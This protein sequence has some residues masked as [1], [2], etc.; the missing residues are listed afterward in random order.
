MQAANEQHHLTTETAK[1]TSLNQVNEQNHQN[2]KQSDQ[3]MQKITTASKIELKR[4]SEVELGCNASNLNLPNLIQ[5]AQEALSHA[6]H[7]HK[8][9]GQFYFLMGIE[10]SITRTEITSAKH[11]YVVVCSICMEITRKHLPGL[12]LLERI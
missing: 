6:Q 1:N 8:N 7:T 12:A 4:P 2:H 3:V 11:G 9:A 10:P 5:H